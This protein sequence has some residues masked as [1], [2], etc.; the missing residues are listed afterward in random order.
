MN[1]DLDKYSCKIC[2][3]NYASAS[4]LFNH[5]KKFHKKIFVKSE[6]INKKSDNGPEKS[7]NGPEKSV[8]SP[9]ES[10]FKCIEKQYNCRYC[11]KL[12]NNKNSRWSHEQKCKATHI[13]NNNQIQNIDNKQ[14]IQ[15]N[16][17]NIN[18][19]INN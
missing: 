2:N 6:D 8:K 7:D 12:Y 3:K 9:K 5:N 4:S 18:N 10:E 1:I 16:I 13:I 17:N 11:K 15:N 19:N 14:L